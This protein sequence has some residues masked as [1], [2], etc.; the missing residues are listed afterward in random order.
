M[1]IFAQ[2]SAETQFMVQARR[3]LHAHPEVSGQE[4]Q[5]AAYLRSQLEKLGIECQQVGDTGLLGRIYGGLGLGRTILLRADIDALP[6]QEQTGLPF[7]SQ[8]S[9][10]M[11]ACGHD[12]HTAALLGAA[13]VL[14]AHRGEFA[15]TVL[16]A[17]QPAEET[18]VGHIP[19]LQGDLTSAAD[20]AFGLHL[21]PELPL[22]TVGVSL[23]ADAA[24][25]DRFRITIHGK[26][27]H[28]SRPQQGIDALYIACHLSEALRTLPSRTLSAMERALVGIGSLHAGT[29]SNIIPETAVLEGTI[30]TFSKQTRS[31][32]QQKLRETS[33]QVAAVYGGTAEVELIQLHGPVIN[34]PEAT[35]EVLSVAR[36][37]FG[38]KQVI[39]S[40][41]PIMGMAADDF[42]LFLDQ[43]KGVYAH[44][45]TADPDRP[46]TCLPLHNCRYD[47]SE[48]AL[49]VAA[50]LHV[51]YALSVLGS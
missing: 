44:V 20:R 7:A 21:W 51:G 29:A 11:H 22:G 28:I 34:D 38:E 32:L 1:D 18:G 19:F 17:F 37:L 23:G 47:I 16:L 42:A 40:P 43:H 39:V 15:G 41:T 46:N 12:A 49:P 9:G 5:T 14:Q 13:K 24:S 27:S 36:E 30:R 50:S 4:Y 45:G 10:V 26:S 8:N 31:L 48:E 25:V 33:E 6:I 2:V 35:Q 3:H